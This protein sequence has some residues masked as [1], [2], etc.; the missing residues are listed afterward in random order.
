MGELI[1]AFL[2][3]F[4]RNPG[5]WFFVI[6]LP[7]GL[8]AIAAALSLESIIRTDLPISYED[9]LLVGIMS[10]ALM[11]TG[12]YTVGYIF[13]DYRKSQIFRQMSITPL[14][15]GKFIFAHIVSRFLIA[16]LQVAV[17]LGIGSVAFGVRLENLLILPFFI[18]IG[19]TLFLNLGIII[20]AVSKNYEEAAPYTTLIGLPLV[21]LGDI[22]FPVQNLPASL[23]RAAN[24]LPLKPL[25]A[26]LRHFSLG[27]PDPNLPADGFFLLVWLVV[28]FLLA[29][30]LFY[31]KIYR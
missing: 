4:F 7:S 30:Y 29:R 27:L 17:L 5:A 16:C 12:L 31:K 2:K 23:V 6:F 10:M 28:L 3:I 22:F 15:G 24:Y 8:F 13:I 18:L 11:Q 20:A 25:T 9:F 26:L 14:S 19:N 1:K 21:F